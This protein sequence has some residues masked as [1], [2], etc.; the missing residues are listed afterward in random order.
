MKDIYGNE[1]DDERGRRHAAAKA[2]LREK[3]GHTPLAHPVS[4]QTHDA[5]C[6]MGLTDHL[7]CEGCTCEHA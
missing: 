2:A 1:L 4:Q 6:P 5:E 3:L 7:G